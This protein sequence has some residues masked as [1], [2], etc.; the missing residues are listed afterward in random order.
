MKSSV[1]SSLNS[2]PYFTTTAV[3]QL[4]TQEG[5]AP[6]SLATA[7]YRWMKMGQL[8][9]LKKGVY[10]TRNFFEL[11][12]SDENFAP[13]I[14]AILVPASYI[15]LD[16]VLQRHGILTDTTY[17][18]TAI[19]LNHPRVI[20]NNLGTFDYHHIKPE[21]YQGYTISTYYGIPCSRATLAKALFDY[22]Y[23][24][25]FR[26]IIASD[27]AES[28]RLNLEEI[29]F[30]DRREFENHVGLSK[31]RKMDRLMKVLRRSV[32]RL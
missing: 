1:L 31:S 22:L 21:L 29:P 30:G 14:S 25:P 26:G 16:Y 6:A 18:V 32:W 28:L 17:P 27:L 15:S 10:M 13:A 7:L 23:L 9:Q 5:I 12:R 8:Y 20:T 24:H 11:H 19:T 2:L 3:K 4:L